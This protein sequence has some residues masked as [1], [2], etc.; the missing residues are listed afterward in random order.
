MQEIAKVKGCRM[1]R[2]LLGAAGERF[3]QALLY[4]QGYDILER[5]FR[6]RFGEID[7]ICQKDG[8]ICMVEVKTRRDVFMGRPA[9]AV[10]VTKENTMRKVANYYLMSHG[11]RERNVTFQVFEILFSQIDM[12]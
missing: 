2:V 12:G 5:N 1:D 10:T 3:A 9:E 4:A 6:C 7:L 11:I 8:T